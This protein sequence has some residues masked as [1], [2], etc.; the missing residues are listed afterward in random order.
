MNEA[1]AGVVSTVSRGVGAAVVGPLVA[2]A[3]DSAEVR[4]SVRE[5]TVTVGVGLALGVATGIVL[6]L[7]LGR[8]G[9]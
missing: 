5:L 2:G 6:G 3:L 9:G 1:T 4:R 8:R 7:A